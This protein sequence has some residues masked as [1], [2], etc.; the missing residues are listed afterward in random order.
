MRGLHD[1]ARRLYL[2]GLVAAIGLLAF[3]V[4]WSLIR[5]DTSDYREFLRPWYEFIIQHGG[6]RALREDFSD[7]NAPYR[8]LLVVLTYLPLPPHGAVKALSVLFDVVAAYFTYRI[9][10]LKYRSRWTPA[11]A[12]LLV[13]MLPTVVLN[14]AMWAQCDSI[15]ASFTLGGVYHLLRRQPWWACVFIGLAVSFKLQAIFILPLLLAMVLLGRVPWRALLA[16]P[17]VY[18][19]LDLPAIVLGADPIRLL[20]IYPRQSGIYPEMTLNAPSVWQFFRGVRDTG[21]MHTAGVLVTVLLVL[22]ICLLLLLARTEPTEPRILLIATVF[23]ILV[24][25]VLPSMHERYFYLADLL[26]VVLAF[27]FP[28]RLWYV[29]I[30]VQ[31]ASLLGYIPGIFES[32]GGE[33]AVGPVDFRILAAIELAMLIAVSYYAIR[34]FRHPGQVRDD[35][36]G[37][38]RSPEVAGAGG[39]T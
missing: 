33:R 37:F 20:T 6:F 18:L 24:P 34:E 14:G 5:Y 32:P 38:A 16:I 4:R 2:I 25:Y 29:P 22:T 39:S 36:G 1:R 12:A 27:Y 11:L 17:V 3:A 31:F 28:R 7:Y 8:Y 9:V 23:V 10:A 26:T 30:G 13:F 15:Y 35:D 19:V 21:V